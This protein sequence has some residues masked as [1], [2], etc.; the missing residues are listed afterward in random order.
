MNLF[1]TKTLTI[2]YDLDKKNF[3]PSNQKTTQGLASKSNPIKIVTSA[4]A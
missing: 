1:Y 3:F 2:G 4:W